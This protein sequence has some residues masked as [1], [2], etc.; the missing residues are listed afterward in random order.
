MMGVPTTTVPFLLGL[1]SVR[2][3]R[4]SLCALFIHR[5]YLY[6]KLFFLSEKGP[7]RISCTIKEW[8]FSYL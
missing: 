2:Y 4:I 6:N 1:H 5:Y 3:S 8:H 7:K